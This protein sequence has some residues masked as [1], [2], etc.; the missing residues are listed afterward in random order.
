MIEL[1]YIDNIWH[2]L[3]AEGQSMVISSLVSE[4]NTYLKAFDLGSARFEWFKN[5]FLDNFKDSIEYFDKHGEFPALP[6][7]SWVSPILN[8]RL[9]LG[10]DIV[11]GSSLGTDNFVQLADTAGVSIKLGAYVG[12]ER[13]LGQLS[14]GSVLP[15]ISMQVNYTHVKPVYDLKESLKEPYKNMFVNFLAGKFKNRLEDISHK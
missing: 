3:R 15:N 4:A 1:L 9:I 7:S 12:L 10:R 14:S 5:D 8:G 11:I 6:F 2:F 13:A